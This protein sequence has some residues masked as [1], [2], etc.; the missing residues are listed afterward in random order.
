MLEQAGNAQLLI[1]II[2]KNTCRIINRQKQKYI[3]QEL[4]EA[5][6]A[7][8][9]IL[10]I[11]FGNIKVHK[12]CKLISE[13]TKD[14]NEIHTTIDRI[15]H[16]LPKILE[17]VKY[18]ITPKP[19]SVKTFDYDPDS[20]IMTNPEDDDRNISF[21]NETLINMLGEIFN[22][23]STNNDNAIE[24][25]FES[26]LVSGKNFGTDMKNHLA[27]K[28]SSNAIVIERLERWCEF[29]SAVGWGKFDINISYNANKILGTLTIKNAFLVDRRN[30]RKICSFLRGYCSGV[31][32]VLAEFRPVSLTCNS[33]PLNN[34][35]DNTCDFNFEIS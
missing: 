16:E 21:R 22:R 34:H 30:E 8:K 24:I 7:K 32:N 12:A 33:C 26:G 1:I 4:E 19:Q 29:D 23:I 9:A 17:S 2:T 3:I 6:K 35:I 28:G 13:Y 27:P 18:N 25:F 31:M 11:V 10:P 15:Y 14:Y 5:K 20:G